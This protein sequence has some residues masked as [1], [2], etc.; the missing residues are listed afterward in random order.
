MYQK[1]IKHREHKRIINKI[2]QTYEEH[3]KGHFLNK[4]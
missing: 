1:K 3:L 2:D 4:Y